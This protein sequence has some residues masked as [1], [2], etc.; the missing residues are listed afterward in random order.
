MSSRPLSRR[1]LL[2]GAAAAAALL[3]ADPAAALGRVP[4]GGTLRMQLAWS[5]RRLDPHDLF[6]P[7]AALFGTAIAAPVSR[8]GYRRP[9]PRAGRAPPRSGA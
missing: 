1:L 7:L 5:T 2:G 3:A 9:A 4:I 6:D 8:H